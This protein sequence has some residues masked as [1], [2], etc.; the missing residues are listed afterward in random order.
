MEALK[1]TALFMRRTVVVL[2]LLIVVP[3]T[4]GLL[5]GGIVLLYKGNIPRAAFV[6]LA[7][8]CI[9]EGCRRSLWEYSH[10]DEELH[11]GMTGTVP[12]STES[13]STVV[14]PAMSLP[15]EFVLLCQLDSGE[16]YNC[17]KATN[18][19]AAAELGELALR[20]RLRVV[21]RKKIKLFS[22]QIYFRPV[23]IHL[24]DATPT[25]LVWADSILANLERHITSNGGPISLY[26]WYRL[27]GDEALLLHRAALT[28]RALLLRDFR[29]E[30]HYP[31]AAVRNALI[32]RL[33]AVSSELVPT[34]EHM[35]LLLDLVEGAYLYRNLGLT[36]TLRQRI[37]RARRTGAVAALPEDLMD[38]SSAL[39]V[40]MRFPRQ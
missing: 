27:R 19:C 3:T 20:R 22:F 14:P 1:G 8:G 9:A 18:G 26:K 29:G 15:E 7:A 28:E 2:V 21:P 4:L 31:D 37:D 23:K 12:A 36:L 13:V 24:S 32:G 17:G 11:E 38:S 40:R 16:V 10:D 30:L 5:I 25:G 39:S 6:F 33:Q 34:D 35:R